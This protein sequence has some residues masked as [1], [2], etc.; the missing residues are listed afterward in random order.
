ML[1]FSFCT[2]ANLC[3]EDP[4]CAHIDNYDLNCRLFE[5]AECSAPVAS[6]PNSGV[7]D[8]A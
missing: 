3:E 8:K 2:C 7:W 6:V 5:A 1:G 4:N